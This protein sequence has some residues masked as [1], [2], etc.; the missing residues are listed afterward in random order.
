M[1]ILQTIILSVVEGVTEFLPVSSTGH[2]ILAAHLLRIPDSDVQKTFDIVIQLGAILAVA[3]LFWRRLTTLAAW[4]PVIIA[5]I[6]T[7]IIGLL[8]HGVVKHYLLGNVAVVVASLFIGGI[9]F[10]LVERRAPLQE[11]AV[12]ELPLA[13]STKQALILGVCQAVAL[14]P[15][16][17]RSGAVIV[18]G[19]LLGISRRA[20]VEFSFLL[21]IPTMLA[22]T[23]LDLAKS[24][25]ELQ[26][27]DISMI[28][29]GF[30][31]SFISAWIVV[32]WFIAYMQRHTLAAF[33]IYRM[34]LAAVWTIFIG[35]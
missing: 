35:L 26:G 14:I 30:I 33:G 3:A 34:V 25:H 17:S 12:E 23:L 18:G 28:A 10:L 6:P 4:K 1:N 2:L 15:G 5:F 21:A 13:L 16:V 7:G 19:L 32:K 27:S 29:I 24:Y 9:F 22:A 31:G 8:L 11:A 20:I